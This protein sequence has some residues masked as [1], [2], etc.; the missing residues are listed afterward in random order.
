MEDERFSPAS[1]RARQHDPWWGVHAARYGFA[2]RELGGGGG[3][4]LD[5]ACG[6]GYGL[7]LLGAAA[8]IV[9][10]ADIDV[11][12][13]REASRHNGVVVAGSGDALPFGDAAFDTVTSFETLEHVADGPLFIGE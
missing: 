3:R 5:V 4:L 12:A 9:V 8:A 1:E 11:A 7:E 2:C 13:L 10:G 6:S